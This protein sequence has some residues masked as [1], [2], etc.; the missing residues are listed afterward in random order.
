M[1]FSLSAGKAAKKSNIWVTP[2]EMMR[3]VTMTRD[4]CTLAAAALHSALP[5]RGAA[6]VQSVQGTH[7]DNLGIVTGAPPKHRHKN[8][9]ERETNQRSVFQAQ[10]RRQP[11]VIA[12]NRHLP[13]REVKLSNVP[14]LLECS[15][16]KEQLGRGKYAMKVAMH[17]EA[18]CSEYF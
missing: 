12:I 3:V 18:D 7:G 2:A 14:G 8:V 9:P 16:K 11:P 17:P 10:L 1:V 13:P 4:V 5:N 15:G 6:E